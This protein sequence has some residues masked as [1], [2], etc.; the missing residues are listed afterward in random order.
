MV[1]NN[2]TDV[3]KLNQEITDNGQI[4]AMSDAAH[5]IDFKDKYREQLRINRKLNRDLR[6]LWKYY[7]ITFAVA[8][9]GIILTVTSCVIYEVLLNNLLAS[10]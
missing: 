6:S 7:V 9:C 3:Q 5:E 1:T 4:L 10:M 2:D 8:I